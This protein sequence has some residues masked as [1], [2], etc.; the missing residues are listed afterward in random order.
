MTIVR[1]LYGFVYGLSIPLTTTMISEI[2]APAVR[3]RFLITINFFVSIG[4]IYAFLL[5]YL[6]LSNFTSGH[7][8]LMM[9]LS[10]LTSLIVG[11]LSY[12][13]LMESPRY[14][15][16]AG[17]VVEGLNVVEEMIEMNKTLP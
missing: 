17:D 1:F 12:L 15:M 8:R 9:C 10:S 13:L 3:G 7:W 14:L 2:T 5:A 4:K 6:C 16:A 11:V